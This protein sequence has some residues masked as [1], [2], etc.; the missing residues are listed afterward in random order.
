MDVLVDKLADM[1]VSDKLR[2]SKR[3]SMPE[4]ELAVEFEELA[5]QVMRKRSDGSFQVRNR[6]MV[7][8]FG[9]PAAV[10]A[11]AWELLIEHELNHPCCK[12]HHLLWAFHKH[13]THDTEEVNEIGTFFKT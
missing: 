12:K 11:K 6:R 10:I 7:A 13:K 4:A 8:F 1:E 3:L 9:A 2:S 5:C